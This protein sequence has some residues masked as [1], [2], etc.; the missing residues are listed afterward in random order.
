MQKNKC[1]SK[2]YTAK[3]KNVD[4]FGVKNAKND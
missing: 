3:I 1:K 2:N 4:N